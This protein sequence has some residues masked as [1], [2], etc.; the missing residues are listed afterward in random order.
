[1]KIIYRPEN[2]YKNRLFT[3][4]YCGIK[5]L[6]EDDDVKKLIRKKITEVDKQWYEH[7]MPGNAIVHYI[8][9][10]CGHDVQL[11]MIE[12]G[13]SYCGYTEGKVEKGGEPYEENSNKEE[14]ERNSVLEIECVYADENGRCHIL[15]DDEP[16]ECPMFAPCSNFQRRQR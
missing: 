8:K 1:M 2:P 9:C 5:F 12:K 14:E 16:K 15:S 7:N 13:S 10:E 4:P 11:D 6:V 3:C